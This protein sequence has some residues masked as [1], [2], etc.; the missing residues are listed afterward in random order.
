MHRSDPLWDASYEWPLIVADTLFRT[1]Q[2][3]RSDEEGT[4]TGLPRK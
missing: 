2:T 1:F 4:E 3:K